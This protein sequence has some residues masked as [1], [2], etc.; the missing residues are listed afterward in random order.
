MPW[1]LNIAYCRLALFASK[2]SVTI[3]YSRHERKSITVL[4]TTF[5]CA[6]ELTFHP[7]HGIRP[8]ANCSLLWTRVPLASPPTSVLRIPPK[9]QVRMSLWKRVKSW[10]EAIKKKNCHCPKR[11]SH[12][13]KKRQGGHHPYLFF[14]LRALLIINTSTAMRNFPLLH[15][16]HL[17]PCITVMLHGHHAKLTTCQLLQTYFQLCALNCGQLLTHTPR[18]QMW[19]R[20][21]ELT[22]RLSR[23]ATSYSSN[24]NLKGSLLTLPNAWMEINNWTFTGTCACDLFQEA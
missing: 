9:A 21:L 19:H 10:R 4:N 15:W 8:Q 23:N 7:R 11:A 5:N 22:C 24:T 20:T 2:I 16:M 6:H 14:Q 1:E 12:I 13:N 17:V 3:I 18:S